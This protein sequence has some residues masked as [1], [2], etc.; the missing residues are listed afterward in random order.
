MDW[1]ISKSHNNMFIFFFSIKLKL[2]LNVVT[3]SR[4]NENI[5]QSIGFSK[6]YISNKPTKNHST[7]FEYKHISI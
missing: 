2:V 4:R 7:N 1:H 5:H 6:Q 3:K